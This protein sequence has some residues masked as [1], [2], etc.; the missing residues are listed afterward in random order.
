MKTLGLI[1]LGRMGQAMAQRLRAQGIQH[2][3]VWDRVPAK[4]QQALNLGCQASESAADVVRKSEITLI[5]INDDAG[6]HALYSGPRGIAAGCTHGTLVVEMSTLQPQTLQKLSE[7]LE[8]KGASLIG[9]PMMGSIPTVLEGKLFLPLGGQAQDIERAMPIFRLISRQIKH[10]GAVSQAHAMKL[11]VN[12]TM[13]AYLQ[14]L[15]EGMAMGVAHGLSLQDMIE[16]FA[17]APTANGWLNMK[18]AVLQ[19]GDSDTTLDI[20]SLRKDVLNAVVAGGQSGVPMVMASAIATA[21]SGAVSNGLGG[22][23]LAQ[24]PK[25]FREN[26][27]QQPA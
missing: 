14:A 2:L 21:L 4:I 11:A 22:V 19:G 18:S 17:Q 9:A 5:M 25:F 23:D 24:F 1:G 27:V 10:M 13:A 26:L 7:L 8:S 12:L 15:A 3:N 6:A 20:S 16:V